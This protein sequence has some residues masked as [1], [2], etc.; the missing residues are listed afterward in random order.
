[1]QFNIGDE[2]VLP[3]DDMF[4]YKD[5]IIRK[6]KVQ[7]IGITEDAAICYVPSYENHPFSQ[8]INEKIISFYKLN[9]K[10]LGEQSI[11]V[12]DDSIIEK[13]YPALQ[14]ENCDNCKEFVEE[15]IRYDDHK[16][17]CRA[18]KENP[19]RLTLATN[20]VFC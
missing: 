18:C 3:V 10:F 11:V 16:F 12:F 17:L 7:V 1:M 15:G 9:K 20:K 13:I 19:W 6:I 4:G 5:K 2:L 8:K 14:G